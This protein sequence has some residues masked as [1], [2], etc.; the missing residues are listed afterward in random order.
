M[1]KRERKRKNERERRASLFDTLDYFREGR[2]SVHEIEGST[3]SWHS[4]CTGYI[5]VYIH[6]VFLIK[7]KRNVDNRWPA[8]NSTIIFALIDFSVTH[9]FKSWYN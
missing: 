7:K 1:E 4:V 2:T 5:Y 9:S 3:A 8:T 6:G